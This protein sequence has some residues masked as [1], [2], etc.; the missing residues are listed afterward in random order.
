MKVLNSKELKEKIY[1]GEKFIVD[2][3]ADWCGPCRV[4]GKVIESV[5]EKLTKENHEVKLYKFNIE[6]DKEM[7]TSLNVRSIPMLIGFNGGKNVSV[8][9]G[10]VPETQIIDMANNI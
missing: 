9:V 5:S 2:M 3:Y 10:V 8:K 6:S 1:N 4:M 7:S